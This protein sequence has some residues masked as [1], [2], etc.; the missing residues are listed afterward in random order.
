MILKNKT[1]NKYLAVYLLIIP[2]ICF[3]LPAFSSC[4][5]ELVQVAVSEADYQKPS[6]YPVNSK[7]IKS[8]SKYGKRINPITKKKA[9][10]SGIDFAIAEGE[11]V[12]SPAKGVVI[13]TKYDSKRGNNITIKHNKK[14]STS[15]FH[16][17]SI[18]VRVGDKLKKRQLIGYVGNTGLSTG[19]HLHYEVLKNGKNKNPK[20]YL[21]K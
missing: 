18:S 3:V 17:M 10:H 15:Y 14:F 13:T 16:L 4:R 8:I 6:I 19:P 9:F 21:P 7:K 11:P 1:S 2:V 20:K 5:E 12:V